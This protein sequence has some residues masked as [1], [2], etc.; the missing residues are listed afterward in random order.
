MGSGGVL[1]TASVKDLQAILAEGSAYV[2]ARGYGVPDDLTFCEGA[3]AV[4]DADPAAV[5]TRA[6]ERVVGSLAAWARVTISLRCRWSIVSTMSR[7]PM[8]WACGP[9]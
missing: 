7:S 3:G 4:A 1:P 2:A 9:V 5:G 6:L 8:P